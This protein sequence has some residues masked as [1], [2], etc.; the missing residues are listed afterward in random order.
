MTT[1]NKFLAEVIGTAILLALG[2]GVVASVVLFSTPDTQAFGGYTN[3]VLGWGFALIVAIYAVGG[4]SGAHLNPAVT[5]AMLLL[6]KINAKDSLVYIIA[7]LIGAFLGAAVTFGVYYYKWV[8]MDFDFSQTAGVFATMPAVNNFTSGFID[9]VVGGFLLVFLVLVI[10]EE[11]NPFFNKT[12]V[13]I[14]IG[15]LLMAIGCGFGAM[16]GFAINPARDFAPR[17]FAVLAGFSNTGFADIKVWTVPIIAPVIGALL[18][19]VAYKSTLG[20]MFN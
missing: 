5:L 13:P 15:I 16:H 19:A 3:I 11:K 6:G 8:Q 7:Q 10:T 14:A 12:L 17:V 9:Q 18:A 20:K 4:I 1:Y 2:T